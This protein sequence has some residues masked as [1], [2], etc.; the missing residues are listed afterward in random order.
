MR[1]LAGQCVGEVLEFAGVAQGRGRR[2][3]EGVV[4]SCGG[5]PVERGEFLGQGVQGDAVAHQ[6]VQQEQ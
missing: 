2:R 4:Q 3:P 1:C 6:V 5:L